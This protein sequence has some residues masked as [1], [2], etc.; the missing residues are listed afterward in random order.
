MDHNVFANVGGDTQPNT[1]QDASSAVSDMQALAEEQSQSPLPLPEVA[2]L[3]T[4][5]PKHDFARLTPL[6][7]EA[8]QAFSQ[9]CDAVLDQSG[10]YRDINTSLS[11][12]PNAIYILGFKELIDPE[13]LYSFC[14]KP[15]EVY[16]V[17]TPLAQHDWHRLTLTQ[18]YSPQESR[19]RLVLIKQVLKGL[20]ALHS[21]GYVHRD[22]KPPNLGVVSQDPHKHLLDWI[23]S[24]PGF[25]GTVGYHAPEMEMKDSSYGKPVDIWALGCVAYEILIGRLSWKRAWNPWREFPADP[26][27][28]MEKLMDMQA[29]AR[30]QHHSIRQKLARSSRESAEHLISRMLDASSNA[31]CTAEQ[32]LD[33]PVM[34]ELGDVDAHDEPRVGSKRAAA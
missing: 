33:H 9:V 6:N 14:D 2:T 23:D 4:L 1:Q 22:I 25:G 13:K 18:P 12:H 8:R 29:E 26:K 20:A 32:A 17:W 15:R 27:V 16:L 30:L 11:Q 19:K 3:N 28:N 21:K 31:R 7:D 24:T 34:R 5:R 10:E